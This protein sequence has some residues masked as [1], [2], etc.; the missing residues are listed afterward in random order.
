MKTMLV[1]AALA[2][3]VLAPLPATA[4]ALPGAVVAVVDLER[5]TSECTACKAATTALRGQVSA[6]QARQNTIATPLEAE[7]KSIQ[8][9]VDALN[10]KSPDA[11]LQARIKAFQ[12]R[13][14]QGAQ[15][16]TSQQDQIKLNQQYIQ[17]QI[18]DKLS[19]IYQ[20][21]M[22]RH[23]AN[24]L[25]EVGSTLATTTNVDVTKD[26]LAGLNAALPTIDATAPKQAQQPQGR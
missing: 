18:A 21:V 24:I 23:G 8:T 6:L 19:P 2:A 13:Q 12:T 9:A 5:V 25:L 1:S 14:Q 17:K 22:Q 15:E 11:T 26:V 10:G 20:S 7:Q 4:Q 16:L 3:S